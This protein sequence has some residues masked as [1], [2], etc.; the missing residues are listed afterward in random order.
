MLDAVVPHQKEGDW[1]DKK[2]YPTSAGS[3]SYLP[4][5]L[6]DVKTLCL[7]HQSHVI[8]ETG[9]ASPPKQSLVHHAWENSGQI[10][11]LALSFSMSNIPRQSA[12]SCKGRPLQEELCQI[13]PASDW[14]TPPE[15]NTHCSHGKG[16]PLRNSLLHWY[17]TLSVHGHPS[18][19]LHSWSPLE[20]PGSMPSLRL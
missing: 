2:H 5:S 17:S 13:S 15:R 3:A 11:F 16:P 9:S 19:C 4:F 6:S 1:H 10:C 7:G 18:A 12:P 14:L 8:T 20:I